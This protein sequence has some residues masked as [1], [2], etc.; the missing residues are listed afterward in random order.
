[1]FVI[2]SVIQLEQRAM[3]ETKQ[4]N[5]VVVFHLCTE[6][7][8]P[9]NSHGSSESSSPGEASRRSINNS[10]HLE[11]RWRHCV[12]RTLPM[13]GPQ[14]WKLWYDSQGRGAGVRIPSLRIS[15]GC[16]ASPSR[17]EMR[18]HASRPC[19]RL[20]QCPR[21]CQCSNTRKAWAVKLR[22]LPFS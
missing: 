5:R 4:A 1:M 20:C 2:L 12:T 3:V 17:R 8:L 13:S 21:S 6:I 11:E 7:T 22:V 9:E 10:E 15:L 14:Y 19:P 16:S 18:M